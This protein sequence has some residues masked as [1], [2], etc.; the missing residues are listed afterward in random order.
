[1]VHETPKDFVLHIMP[2]DNLLKTAACNWN[3][4][5]SLLSNQ[6]IIVIGVTQDA[7]VECH[8]APKQNNVPA[9]PTVCIP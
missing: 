8:K 1:L 2:D 3:A 4:E 7:G 9:T 5:L 6:G